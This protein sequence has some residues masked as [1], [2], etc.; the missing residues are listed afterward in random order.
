MLRYKDVLR[1]LKDTHNDKYVHIIT[2]IMLLK[3]KVEIE[4]EGYIS[5]PLSYKDISIWTGGITTKSFLSYTIMRLVEPDAGWS[6]Y[7][8]E[9]DERRAVICMDSSGVRVDVRSPWIRNSD[10]IHRI[11]YIEDMDISRRI[12]PRDILDY[13]IWI[14]EIAKYISIPNPIE[15]VLMNNPLR[16]FQTKIRIPTIIAL[17]SISL[18]YKTYYAYY[19]VL[20]GI[21]PPGCRPPVHT[22]R[23]NTWFETDINILTIE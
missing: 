16:L 4:S 6:L 14:D 19:E 23:N 20:E 3:E 12:R 10:I 22:P 9:Y 15:F 8:G 18:L 13:R 5:Q 1:H 7:L 11:C 2:S 17:S 21:P